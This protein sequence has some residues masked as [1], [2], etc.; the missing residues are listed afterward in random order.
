LTARTALG[1]WLPALRDRRAGL[2]ALSDPAMATAA[3][4]PATPCVQELDRERLE[5]IECERARLVTDT[6]AARAAL[7]KLETR[8]DQAEVALAAALAAV[9]CD[10]Q[11]HLG[12]CGAMPGPAAAADPVACP[13]RVARRQIRLGEL[14][15]ARAELREQIAT[16]CLAAQ[17]RAVRVD[18][19]LRRCCARYARTLLRRHPDGP[20]LAR[21]GWPCLGELPN[22]VREPR[23]AMTLF[24]TGPTGPTDP[25]DAH[26][27]AGAGAPSGRV[28]PTRGV[29]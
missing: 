29:G 2:P 18:E 25:A 1:L 15:A 8:I 19:Y 20:A 26:L 16:Q 5:R 9:A 3:K 27:L 12:D 22:W 10:D 13:D 24:P 17:S 23:P 21:L 6:A 4:P 11:D 7:H 14:Q 28:R